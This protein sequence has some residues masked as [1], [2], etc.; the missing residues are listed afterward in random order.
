M[1]LNVLEEIDQ[2]LFDVQ[3]GTFIG[4]IGQSRQVDIVRINSIPR[5]VAFPSTSMISKQALNIRGLIRG[6]SCISWSKEISKLSRES[7]FLGIMLRVVAPTFFVPS[8]NALIADLSSL[9]S[10]YAISDNNVSALFFTA[11]KFEYLAL[12]GWRKLKC[13]SS[14]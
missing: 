10:T 13:S 11:S 4:G 9:C 8:A 12:G 6:L 14:C 3:S 2:G 7:A 5:M 1:S